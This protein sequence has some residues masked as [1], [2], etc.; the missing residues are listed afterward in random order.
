MAWGVGGWLLPNFLAKAGQD[1]AIR[2]RKR[3]ADELTTTFASNYT[4]E[5]SLS[6]ALK[7]EEV[8]KYNA[9]TTGQ[10]YLI[11]PQMPI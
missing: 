11:C 3:V 2:L 4:G 6:D 8:A 7:A 5:L 9:K 10:K 1:V